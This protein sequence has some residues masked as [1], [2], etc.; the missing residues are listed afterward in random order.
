M[1][2]IISAA[3]IAAALLSGYS[4]YHTSNKSEIDNVVLENIEALS[5]PEGGSSSY[6]CGRAVYEADDDWYEDTKKFKWCS[7]GCPDSEGT[8]PKY[9][10]CY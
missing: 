1:K 10:D 4:I 5:E 3:C 9:I 6:G 7:R 2:K 8:S